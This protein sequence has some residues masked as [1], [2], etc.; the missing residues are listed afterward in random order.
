MPL[1]IPLLLCHSHGNFGNQTRVNRFRNEIIRTESKIIHMI[2]FVHYVGNR[3]FCQIGDSMY[4][5][6]LHFFI[7]SFGLSIQS[8]AEN[9]RE[10]DYVIDL[11]R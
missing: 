7:D 1:L 9:I 2:G 10:T 6:Q 11:V 5:S 3:L 8:S 4:G